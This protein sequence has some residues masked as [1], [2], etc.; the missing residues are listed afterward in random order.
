MRS[1][2]MASVALA[3]LLVLLP[4]CGS[5]GGGD[6]DTTDSV[7]FQDG[8]D[9]DL[10]E[11][12]IPDVVPDFGPEPDEITL[13]DTKP[14]DEISQPD[15]ACLPQCGAKECGD[16]GCGGSCGTCDGGLVCLPEGLCVPPANP[17]EVGTLVITEI[18]V[19]PKAVKDTDGEWFEIRNTTANAINLQ[20]LVVTDEGTETFTITELT[21][22]GPNKHLVLGR[23][24]KMSENGG[25]AVGFVYTKFDLTNEKDKIVLKLGDVVIDSVSWDATWAIPSGASLSL[26]PEKQNYE[27]N[28]SSTAW[29]PSTTFILGETGDMGTPG[30]INLTCDSQVCVPA[31]EG[32]QCGPNGCGGECGTCIPGT[33]CSGGLCVAQT[34]QAPTVGDLI[35]NELMINPKNSSDTNG[36]WIE[37]RN[38]SSKDLQLMG[39]QVSDAEGDSFTVATPLTLPPLGFVVLGR[40]ATAD[41][42]GGYAPDYVFTGF[43]LANTA[44]EVIVKF[45]GVVLDQVLYTTT[46]AD[47]T[48]NWSIP[49]GSSL[50]VSPDV[51]SPEGND[52]PGAWCQQ[53]ALMPLV[54]APNPADKATPG[55]AN[56]CK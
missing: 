55:K 40:N 45:E 29:C 33:S 1:I 13:P 50:A 9:E 42:N 17:P 27:L 19:D 48:G 38:L 11:V 3:W 53:E 16:D 15:T 26:P 8:S 32:K 23:S 35:V 39:L 36:E 4:A 21:H 2:W 6:A 24:S 54:V 52:L 22:L 44:D 30:V 41:M 49:D 7:S 47:P 34:G 25:V 10:A 5:S 14:V 37:L 46:A 12:V 18:M 51:T 28:D 43:T 20:G 56:V 31:C